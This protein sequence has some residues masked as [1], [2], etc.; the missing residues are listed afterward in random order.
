[1]PFFVA[2]QCVPERRFQDEEELTPE[3]KGLCP[4]R[5]SVFLLPSS[6]FGMMMLTK[7]GKAVRLSSRSQLPGIP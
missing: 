7:A 2:S 4:R 6:L 3:K 5:E 1:M